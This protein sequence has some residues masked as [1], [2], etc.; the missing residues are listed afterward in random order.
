[1]TTLIT[2]TKET[3]NQH[4][5]PLNAMHRWWKID[6]ECDGFLRN[7]HICQEPLT[8]VLIN[9]WQEYTSGNQVDYFKTTKI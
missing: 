9:I 8:K 3:S 2:A 7:V 5:N 1:M 4:E 6:I